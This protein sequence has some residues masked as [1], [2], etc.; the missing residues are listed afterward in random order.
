MQRMGTLPLT[1]AL[2]VSYTAIWDYLVIN[3]GSE[4]VSRTHA[5]GGETERDVEYSAL[6]DQDLLGPPNQRAPLAP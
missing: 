5:V 4:C 2:P 1:F 3:R 6:S